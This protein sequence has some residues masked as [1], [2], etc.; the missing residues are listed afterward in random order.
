MDRFINTWGMVL[1]QGALY[2]LHMR[3]GLLLSFIIIASVAIAGLLYLYGGSAFDPSAISSSQ[4][5]AG[6]NNT[7]F[8]ILSAGQNAVGAEQ[9]V[10]YRITTEDQLVALWGMVHGENG[11]VVPKVDFE[12]YEVLAIFDGSHTT[13]G[14]DIRVDDMNEV[15]GKR[16]LMLTHTEPGEECVVTQAFTSPFVIIQVAASSLPLGRENH[17]EINQCQ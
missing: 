10:N 12:K 5:Q 1:A 6:A 8:T 15:D 16:V 9:R 2:Y 13:G 14:Y 7:D 17:K 3:K 11:P 4:T